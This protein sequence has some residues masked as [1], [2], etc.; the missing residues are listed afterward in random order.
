MTDVEAAELCM[1]L[2]ELRALVSRIEVLLAANE[3]QG[4][5]TPTLPCPMGTEEP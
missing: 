1:L 5:E 4:R 3:A 2:A